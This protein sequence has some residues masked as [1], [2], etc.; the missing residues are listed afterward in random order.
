MG[1]ITLGQPA[2]T[3]SGGEAQRIKLAKSLGNAKNK[4]V[5]FILDEPTKGLHFHDEVK[6]LGLMEELVNQGNSMIVIEHE[7]NVLRNCDW[8]IELGPGGGP[9]GGKIIAEG[10]PEMLGQNKNSIIQRYI[11][12]K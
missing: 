1:Y 3:L 6:L 12:R 8:I 5:L 11:N 4:N 7:T 10:T 9:Q 2:T